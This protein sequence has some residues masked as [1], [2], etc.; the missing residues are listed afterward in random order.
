MFAAKLRQL[1]PRLLPLFSKLEGEI[2]GIKVQVQVKAPPQV[3][4]ANLK[5]NVLP[6]EFIENFDKLSHTVSNPELKL[7]I[8]NLVRKRSKPEI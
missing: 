7:A 4:R 3:Q 1:L 5:K 8:T 6:S 2:T